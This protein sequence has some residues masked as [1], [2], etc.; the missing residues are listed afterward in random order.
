MK[1]A[2]LKQF[3]IKTGLQRMDSTIVQSNIRRMSRLQLLVEIIHRFYRMLSEE[4][5]QEHGELFG[6]YVK[7]DSLHFCYRVDRDEIEDRLVRGGKDLSCML[8]RF[9]KAHGDKKAYRHAFRVFSEHFR[10]EQEC[11]VVRESK[12]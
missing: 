8:K 5:K 10:F 3:Q 4:E 12:E 11:I 6:D 7:E 2:E 9:E 1:V